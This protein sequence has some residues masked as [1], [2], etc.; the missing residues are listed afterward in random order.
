MICVCVVR[1]MCRV[2]WKLGGRK[3]KNKDAADKDS[4]KP[5]TNPSQGWPLEM[6]KWCL[7]QAVA[8]C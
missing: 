7:H 6:V 8:A 4:D 1:G 2:T 5:S 3:R